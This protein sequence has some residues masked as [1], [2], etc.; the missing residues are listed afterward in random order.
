MEKIIQPLPSA[1]REE[2]PA[3]TPAP[4]A[5]AAQSLPIEKPFAPTVRV[6]QSSV[7]QTPAPQMTRPPAVATNSEGVP[8]GV[9]ASNLNL[10]TRPSLPVGV[11]I[12]VLVILVN[13]GASFLNTNTSAVYTL[14]MVLDLLVAFGLL[15]RI[16]IFRM[17]SIILQS[18]T[19]VLVALVIVGLI[20]VQNRLN[21]LHS[22]YEQAIT[23]LNPV[24]ETVQQKAGIASLN[25]KIESQQKQVG[26]TI[27]TAY[28][29]DGLNIVADG[30]VIIYLT[31]PRVKAAFET[32]SSP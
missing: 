31:R 5:A 28:I 10:D 20:L 23:H 30:V 4:V 18:I 27:R 6:T 25:K 1:D 12:I 9:A 3:P 16:E 11:Y 8:I 7:P 17:V 29:R 15:L 22:Q 32:N 14:A 2:S 19:I 21:Q 13:V 26:K 24:T